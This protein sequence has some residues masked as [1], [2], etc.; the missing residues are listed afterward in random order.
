M[1]EEVHI[2]DGYVVA[3]VGADDSAVVDANR[4]AEVVELE[5]EGFE[6]ADAYQPKELASLNEVGI[7]W[8][9]D[10]QLRPVVGSILILLQ[11]GDL[12]L[13]QMPEEV[14]APVLNI[15]EMIFILSF[16]NEFRPDEVVAQRRNGLLVNLIHWRFNG[17]KNC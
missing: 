7:E 15:A 1:T 10:H 8:V 17:M 3:N 6:F 4:K 2:V 5:K 14:G 13:C 9:G 16:R 12:L 11:S